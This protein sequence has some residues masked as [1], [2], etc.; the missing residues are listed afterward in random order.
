[1]PN[2][3]KLQ[4]KIKDLRKS[5]DELADLFDEYQQ[6]GSQGDRQNLID[7]LDNFSFEDFSQYLQEEVEGLL[8][9]HPEAQEFTGKVAIEEGRAVIEGDVDFSETETNH[10]PRVI[11]EIT[12]KADFRRSKV[13]DLSNLREIGGSANFRHSSVKDLSKLTHV[14]GSADFRDSLVKDLS[15][16]KTIGGRANFDRSNAKDLS[17]LE[18]IGGN[19]NFYK[20]NITDLDNLRKIGRDA[21]FYKSNITNLSSLR[22]IGSD[23]NF[24]KSNVTYISSLQ[25][26]KGD[27][28]I[29]NDSDLDLSGVQIT[30]EIK[31]I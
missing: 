6:T 7:A 25:V 11:T 22:T 20:S 3:Q 18:R 4:E 15:N 9:E 29:D 23:A 12:G 2:C 26:I 13:I 17:N 19:A 1:M 27:V 21:D 14:G 31:R 16:L 28:L 30:G 24:L 5:K 10:F 8:A